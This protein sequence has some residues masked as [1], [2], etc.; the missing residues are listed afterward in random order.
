MAISM[1]VVFMILLAA[2]L[3]W[4]F[5][6]FVGAAIAGFILFYVAEKRPAA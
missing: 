3:R 4:T 5:L 1:N 6:V 2:A